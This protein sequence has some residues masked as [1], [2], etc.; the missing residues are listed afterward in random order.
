MKKSAFLKLDDKELE[1][2]LRSNDFQKKYSAE[3]VK[4]MIRKDEAKPKDLATYLEDANTPEG[5]VF[6]KKDGLNLH[7]ES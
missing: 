1:T 5:K 7:N 3:K 4:E 2:Y 6:I